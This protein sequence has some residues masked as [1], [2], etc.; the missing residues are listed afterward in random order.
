MARTK[1][2]AD[3]NLL[4]KL[5]L[6]GIPPAPRCLSQ[7]EVTFDIDG[8]GTLDVSARDECAPCL[9]PRRRPLRLTPFSMALILFLSLSESTI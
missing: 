9:L 3:N 7:V 1:M 2:T 4:G 6:D 5:Y 8:D